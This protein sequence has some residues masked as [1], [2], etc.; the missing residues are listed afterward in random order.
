M[1][2]YVEI[3]KK[4]GPAFGCT[5]SNSLIPA[6]FRRYKLEQDETN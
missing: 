1:D 2:T 6:F 4:L 3:A 5:D